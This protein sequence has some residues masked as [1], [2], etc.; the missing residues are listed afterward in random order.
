MTYKQIET[1]R[2]ARLWLTQVIVPVASIA[3]TAFVAF[4][5]LGE[6]VKSKCKKVKNKLSIKKKSKKRKVN[7]ERE[8]ENMVW[9]KNDNDGT[10]RMKRFK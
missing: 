2:E 5:E 3:I 1:S 8:S 9:I 7:F 6:A 10:Y 4:P